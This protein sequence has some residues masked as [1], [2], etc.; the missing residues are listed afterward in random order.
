M[1]G[2][3]RVLSKHVGGVGV[4]KNRLRVLQVLHDDVHLY[5][6]LDTIYVLIRL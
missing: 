2:S 6:C 5:T 4:V 1:S 3:M